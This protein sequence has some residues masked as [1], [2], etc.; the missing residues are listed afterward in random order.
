MDIEICI[1]KKTNKYL[2]VFLFYKNS[3]ISIIISD[4]FILVKYKIILAHKGDFNKKRK[5]P[6]I[7]ITEKRIIPDLIEKGV[8]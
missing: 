7:P 8:F 1:N 4:N 6:M 2:S 3:V 5:F